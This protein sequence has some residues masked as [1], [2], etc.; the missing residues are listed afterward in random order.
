MRVLVVDDEPVIVK[1]LAR[2][3]RGDDVLGAASAEEALEKVRGTDYDLI[4]LDYRMPG[5]NGEWFLRHAT[6]PP[7]TKVLLLTGFLDHAVVRTMFDLGICGYVAKPF[8]PADL[9]R[10][11]AL[12]FTPSPAMG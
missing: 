4:F 10:Q 12:H 5:N 8:R 3:F 2:T 11:V 7:R 9:R 1:T 6:L